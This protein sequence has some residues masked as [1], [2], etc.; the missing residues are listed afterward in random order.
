M[1]AA[2]VW[3]DPSQARADHSCLLWWARLQSGDTAARYIL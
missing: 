3:F 2:A 1:V